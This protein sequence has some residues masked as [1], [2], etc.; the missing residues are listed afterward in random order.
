MVVY[1]Q[2]ID[3]IAKQNIVLAIADCL[4]SETNTEV[5]AAIEFSILLARK[6]ELP[7]KSKLIAKVFALIHS[8]EASIVDR[9][10]D[11][12]ER[13]FLRHKN[14]ALLITR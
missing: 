10:I 11:F 8:K 1:Y 14:S 4:D 6:D 2:D 13:S 5:Q 3:P 9:T 12:F 7:H